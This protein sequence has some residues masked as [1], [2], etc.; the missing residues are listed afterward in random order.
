[1]SRGFDELEWFVMTELTC[2]SCHVAL[3]ANRDPHGAI[4]VCPD[5]AGSAANLA[6]LRK[7][8]K[9]G[10]ANDFWR[11]APAQGA[12]SARPCPACGESMQGFQ[13]PL[14]GHPVHLDLCRQCQFVWFDAGELEALPKAV[15]EKADVRLREAEAVFGV[16][17]QNEL[18]AAIDHKVEKTKGWL[19]T[20]W[21]A[22][23]IALGLI[24]RY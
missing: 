3:R 5:C 8:L 20:G 18:N 21:L 15:I 10:M 24:V 2:P 6:I 14:D 17:L 7:R 22:L 11:Q 1:L 12:V 16:R 13:T 23:D 19:N 4:W 9:E